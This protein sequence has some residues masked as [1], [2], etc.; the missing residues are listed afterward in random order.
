MTEVNSSAFDATGRA[1]DQM[2]EVLEATDDDVVAVRMGSGTP[3][4]YREFYDL[5]V[6]KTERHGTVHVYEEGANWT[7][8]T[9]LS[10]VHGIVPDLRDGLKFDID[11]YAAVGDSRWLDLLYYQWVAITPVWP[12]A[13]NEMRLYATAERRDALGWVQTGNLDSG[14]S[15]TSPSADR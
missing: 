9:Y 6:E 1:T 4:G 5:L 14:S 3:T 11:R 10:H 15:Y 8:S 12:V 2:F 13:P 7:L